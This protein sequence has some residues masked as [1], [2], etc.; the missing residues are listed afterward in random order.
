LNTSYFAVY[1]PLKDVDGSV[2]G[3]LLV[4][5]PGASIFAT[6]S[7]SIEMTF[8]VAVGLIALSIFPSFWIARYIANQLD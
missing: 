8:L 1:S 5:R 7:R 2:V 6:A 3:M 4:G